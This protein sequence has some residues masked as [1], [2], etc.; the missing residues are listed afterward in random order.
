MFLP[1]AYSA[2][3]YILIISL[4][5]EIFVLKTLPSPLIRTLKLGFVVRGVG[6]EPTQAYATGAYWDH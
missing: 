3:M 6:F 5:H 1:A 4:A 2:L